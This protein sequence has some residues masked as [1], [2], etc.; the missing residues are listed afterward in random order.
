MKS[1][2]LLAVTQLA[3]E[4]NLPK[5]MVF[6]AVE[7]AL[8][9]TYRKDE[10][11]RKHDFTVNILPSSGEIKVYA[12]KTVVDSLKDPYREILLDE[13]RAMGKNVSLGETIE[14][15]I[16]PPNAGR[17]GA[18]TAKQIV[19]QRL[20]EAER[21]FIFS[22]LAHKEGEIISGLVQRVEPRQIVVDLGRAE[23]ILPL[24]EQVRTEH[25]RVGQR[26][27]V[28]LLEVSQTNRGPRLVL[29]R[30]HPNLVRRL[31][32]LEIPEI[33]NGVI[34][35]KAIAREPGSRTKLA[36]KE[37]QEGVDPV[38]SCIGLR[39]VR[40]QN[41]INELQGEKVDVIRWHPDPKTFIANALSP[42]Q[43]L[44]VELNV[45]EGVAL[46][47]VPDG[48]LSLAIGKEGQ[49]ARLA[50]KLTGWK[51]DI[52]SASAVEEE[53]AARRA[54][55]MAKEAVEEEVKEPVEEE[56]TEEV[57]PIEEVIEEEPQIPTSPQIRFAE[58]ILPRFA[59][60]NVKGKK[61]K[62]EAAGE[63][64]KAKIKKKPKFRKPLP[65]EEEEEE[66]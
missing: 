45:E 59:R 29:S 5:E 20:R 17:I 66:Y 64:E 32:E 11:V 51:I 47:V 53:R 22:E 52:K 24:S 16:Q 54:E 13:A 39:G 42:A 41:I 63:I 37:Q 18:Q 19:M 27:K 58:D 49:N 46:A 28:Y 61:G 15:E 43:V 1:D 14:V 30:T 6:K 8:L 44:E 55:E 62:K 48:Q 40:I 12:R 35:I 9:S 4:R 33:R 50:A 10:F 7:G 31:F 60:V 21:E 34:E 3:T 38:G 2:F 56:I 57:T 25:Y 65:E 26:I 23:G 36:V